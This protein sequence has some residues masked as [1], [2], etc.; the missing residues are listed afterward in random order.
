M[1]ERQSDGKSTIIRLICRVR[2]E[3][4]AALKV[5]MGDCPERV[6]LDLSELTIVD[7]EVIRHLSVKEQEGTR[8][9][10]CPPYIREWILRE[11]AEGEI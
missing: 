9:V 6:I 8:L 3:H 7:G 10:S 5:Q 2:A 4:L 1:I 11:R